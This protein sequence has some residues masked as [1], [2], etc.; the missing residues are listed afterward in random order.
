M[1]ATAILGLLLPSSCSKDDTTVDNRDTNYGYAQFKLYKEASYTETRAIK[2]ELDYLNEAKKVKINLIDEMGGQI[3]QTLILSSHDATSAEFGLRSDKL[4][5]LVGTYKIASFE[6]YDSLDGQLYNGTTQNST[7]TIVGGG[8]NQHDLTVRVT[9]RGSMTLTMTK[10]LSQIT[11]STEDDGYMLSNVALVD[12]SVRHIETARTT[13]FK[14]VEVEFVI[15]FD[16]DPTTHG[17]EESMLVSDSLLYLEA[18]EYIV[19]KY[20]TKTAKGTAFETNI[21]PVESR[22][23]VVDNQ[24]TNA[25]VQ[26]TLKDSYAYIRDY[27]AL[28]SI[29]EALDGPNWYYRGETYTT[30]T[31]W[32]F[33]CD[34][35]L[36]GYQPGVQLHA[37]GRV[38]SVSISGYGARGDMPAA[39]G[40]L[41]EL[42]E[43]Y[44]GTHSEISSLPGGVQD[45]TDPGLFSVGE[46]SRN[47]MELGKQYLSLMHP[48]VQMSAPIAFGLKETGVSIPEVALHDIYNE[49]EIFDTTGRQIDMRPKDTAFG[50]ITNDVRSLP[51]EIGNLTKLS[52]IYIAN[53]TMTT[54][55]AEIALLDD[56]TDL[57]I[58]NCPNMVEFP[59]AI[60]GM[61][62][63]Q[64]LNFSHNLQWSAE[65]IYKGFD[66]LAKNEGTKENPTIEL[67]YAN[68]NNLE[69]LPA[70]M[71]M[72]TKIGLLDL[73]YNKINT[74]EAPIPDVSPVQFFL[75]NNQI[76]E[77]PTTADGIFC[78]FVD[79]ESFSMNN[80]KLTQIP[81]IFHTRYIY[82][83]ESV[84]FAYNEITG[85]QNGDAYKG[86]K[87]KTFTIAGNKNL[88]KFPVELATSG[89]TIEYINAAGC[90]ID[91]IPEGSFL[92]KNSFY[93]RSLDLTYNHL[94]ELPAEFNAENLPYLYGV[95]FSYN[96]FDYFPFHPLNS[97]SLVVYAL[98]GQRD[99]E[100]ER[101]M[102]QWPEGI[103]QH[104]GLRALFLGSNDIREVDDNISYLIYTLDISDNPRIVFDASDICSAWEAGVYN[105]IYDKTQNIINCASMLE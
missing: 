56:L 79:M 38:A 21:S 65:E 78:E 74:I 58:Y 89:S 26:I 104:L 39:L 17:Y 7:L 94:T 3:S 14:D 71:N 76:A 69:R 80:N 60:T 59:M 77:V 24:T 48:A 46:L 35:D 34:P 20:V 67:L 86:V 85:V 82:T 103:S 1:I 57:E 61:K 2:D 25:E 99:A 30:G 33:N 18:G 50:T 90:S 84:S 45:P 62:S 54:I 16:D 31:N 98:R 9:P 19:T 15:D 83:M 63:L 6:L 91:E 64:F 105:L 102:R 5:L 47:R 66:A 75:D 101:I 88:T 72:M 42:I 68:F 73:S 28:K 55:P 4:R 29:W 95:D 87:A 81:D 44:I 43:L 92:G 40:D 11:R 97:A 32:D 37:N 51:A 12:V 23:T 22:F 100:G 52:I 36:W 53:S 41:T 10:D 49:S 27:E 96:R 8:L 70:S 93:T 13:D